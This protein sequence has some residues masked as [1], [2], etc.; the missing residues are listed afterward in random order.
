MFN[1]NTLELWGDMA[2]KT[3]TMPSEVVI[4]L[5]KHIELQEKTID[6]LSNELE[7][8][9]DQETRKGIQDD[10]YGVTH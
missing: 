3:N 10:Y 7:F 9:E 5:I 8:Y 2:H 1:K 6:R 4:E